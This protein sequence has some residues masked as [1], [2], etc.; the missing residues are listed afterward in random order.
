MARILF[1][2]VALLALTVGHAA[3]QDAKTVLQAASKAMGAD[4]LKTIQISGTGFVAGVGQSYS[5][6][7]DWPKFELTSYTKTIDYDAKSSGRSSPAGRA[8]IRRVA[9]AG[10]RSRVSSGRYFSSTATSRGIWTGRT[11]SR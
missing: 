9:A 6:D 5:A 7:E 10:H 4:N 11:L 1:V 3:A 8:T 2:L